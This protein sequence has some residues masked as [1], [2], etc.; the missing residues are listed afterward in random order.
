MAAHVASFLH[1]GFLRGEQLRIVATADHMA[2]IARQLTNLGCPVERA[3]ATRGLVWWDAASTLYT[4]MGDGRVDPVRLRPLARE[5]SAADGAARP[6]CI[7]GE[8][9]DILAS[10]GDLKGALALESA[11]SRAISGVPSAV[12]C[13]YQATH[14]SDQ[15]TSSAL[16]A[17]CRE[18]DEVRPSPGDDLATWLLSR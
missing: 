15:S 5:L 6:T 17:I 10:R 14:F 9:V 1:R 12:L 8:M 3:T 2:A 18:H 11:W 4:L 7:Y 13:G 16:H